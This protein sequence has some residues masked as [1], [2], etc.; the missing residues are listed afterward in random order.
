MSDRLSLERPLMV[1]VKV[2]QCLSGRE[3]GR[4]DPDL[5]TVR[6]SGGDL[7]VQAG[8]QK[9]LVG[10]AVTSGPLAQ[11]FDGGRKAMEP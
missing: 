1:E 9:L 6:L 7:A 4:P 8:G 10:P 5:P 3:L 2:L 11:A